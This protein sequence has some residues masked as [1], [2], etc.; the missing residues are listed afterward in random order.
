LL[1]AFQS[2]NFRQAF[3]EILK[4]KQQWNILLKH[5]LIIIY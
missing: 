1:Y 2:T 4:C 5:T 3:K